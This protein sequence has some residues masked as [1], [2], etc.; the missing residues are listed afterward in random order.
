MAGNNGSPK[1]GGK[2]EF[3]REAE[4]PAT[5][6]RK[7]K[8]SKHSTGNPFAVEVCDMIRHHIGERR[9]LDSRRKGAFEDRDAAL[10]ELAE[11][12][13]KESPEAM[14]LK[15]QHSDAIVQIDDL[16]S[17]IKWHN[18]QL[19]ELVEKADEPGFDF[20]YDPEPTPTVPKGRNKSGS[21]PAVPEAD[22]PG[23]EGVDEHLKAHV[24][25]LD[26]REDLKGK[27]VAAGLTT[28]GAVVAVLDG[29]GD[30]RDEV[31]LNENQAAEVKR[32]VKAYRK[33]HRDAARKV[34]EVAA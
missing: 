5:K 30:I 12:T 29:V 31:E 10:A 16:N 34:E 17:R 11:L 21:G 27:L 3:E 22:A 6:P 14:K 24:N 32:A 4:A 7:K 8:K 13:D 18:K 26:C 25:E 1:R 19:D 20:M 33:K 15:S 23:F 9:A 28:I 2:D